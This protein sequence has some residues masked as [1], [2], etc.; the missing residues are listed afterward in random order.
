MPSIRQRFHL[1]PCSDF[2]SHFSIPVWT[3]YHHSSHTIMSITSID[4]AWHRIDHRRYWT[5]DAVWLAASPHWPGY[6]SDSG[7]G[8]GPSWWHLTS[9][10]LTNHSSHCDASQNCSQTKISGEASFHTDWFWCPGSW[11]D[12]TITTTN[13]SFAGGGYHMR[14]QRVGNC[15]GAHSATAS[16]ADLSSTQ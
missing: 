2:R 16:W 3:N 9:K 7:T 14:T 5:D 8:T 4:L 12:T 15:A 11:A 10:S 1:S 6:I 13:K